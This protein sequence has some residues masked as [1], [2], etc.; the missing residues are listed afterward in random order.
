MYPAR[1]LCLR[2]LLF[3][4]GLPAMAQT[5]QVIEREVD[6]PRCSQSA[7]KMVFSAL[8]CKSANRSSGAGRADPRRYQRLATGGSGARSAGACQFLHYH[9]AGGEQY[10]RA[11]CRTG[12]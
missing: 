9:D 8:K 11:R 4:L 10:H 2:A 3:C 12:Q 1:L 7:A 5:S 6:V